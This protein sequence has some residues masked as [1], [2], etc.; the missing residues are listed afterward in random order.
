MHDPN[1][2]GQKAPLMP[3]RLMDKGDFSVSNLFLRIPLPLKK[4]P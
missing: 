4:T 3:L 2:F 1:V